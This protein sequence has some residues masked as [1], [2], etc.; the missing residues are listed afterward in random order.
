M[1]LFARATDI[2][3]RSILTMLIR[4]I[5][6]DVKNFDSML[7]GVMVSTLDFESSD[8]GSN[9]GRSYDCALSGFAANSTHPCI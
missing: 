4:I 3:D 8:P 7:Y 9:P 5:K 2:D 1:V 6:I